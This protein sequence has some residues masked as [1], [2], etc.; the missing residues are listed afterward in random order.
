L[1]IR[2]DALTQG[3]LTK[4][5]LAPPLEGGKSALPGARLANYQFAPSPFVL[6]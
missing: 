4:K 1:Y 6:S 5:S 3:D 2:L